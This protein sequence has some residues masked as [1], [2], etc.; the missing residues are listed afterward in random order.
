ML[1]HEPIIKALQAYDAEL[2]AE[3]IILG[4]PP[5]LEMGDVAIP[6]F[7]LAKKR[8]MSPALLAR[9]VV[10]AVD[11]GEHVASAVAVGPYVNLK[12]D[13]NR[14]GYEIVHAVLQ[15]G[16]QWGGGESGLGKRVLIEHTS[17]N[18]NAS[19]HVGRGRCAMIGDSVT[20]LLRFEGYDVEVHYYVNDMGRQIG[21]L[22]L[23][24][25]ELEGIA[26][27]KILEA[28]V[29]ANKRAEDDPDFAAR[30]YA[31]LAKIEEGDN[32]AREKFFRVT[33]LCLQGQLEVLQRLGAR[34]DFFDHES[35][36]VNDARLALI[37]KALEAKDALFTDEDG[38]RVVDLAKLG[39]PAEEGRYFVLR[40]ANG[41]SM[42]GCRD[43]L[44]SLDKYER[45]ADIN[46]MVLGED[47]KLYA[48]QMALILEA[49]G[50]EPPEVIYYSYILL[51]D[52][53]MSTRQGK[54]VLL[55]DFLDQAASQ[56]LQRVMEQ[57][58]DLPDQEH[59]QIAEQVA[60]SAIR[61][62]VL[63]VKPSKNVI[64][65]ME[66]A[67]SF[68]GDTGPYVQYCC[69]R[70]R[71]ILRKW[72]KTVPAPSREGF[73]AEGDSE[74]VLLNAMAAFPK[75]IAD[76][77]VQRNC[78]PIANYVLDLAHAF[79]GF[80]HDC[81]VLSATDERLLHSRLQL[82]RAA[83]YTLSNALGILGIDTPERM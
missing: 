3:D 69:A 52:G 59:R 35:A 64:F 9:E 79:T 80:Y 54:V 51:A 2:D 21:L 72:D 15:A 26:F 18:P 1:Y 6:M 49:A 38:R 13:R 29:T 61:F 7:S 27:D 12:L 82:C 66:S 75:V 53:K 20:R 33:E 30:G 60:V 24:A 25:D 19:P 67:L 74:W 73:R 45:R 76:S 58:P 39:Y 37:E 81:P 23:V 5:A 40:R 56:A 68:Q 57:F 17:I 83:L 10:A 78:A 71:S 41:S 77:A 16:E 8:K 11:F 46:L 55:S 50:I 47:H 31:M 70:I 36:Y 62:A 14:V 4:A 44:Y 28:Y 22:V 34:Y 32:E 63:R 65:D 42:Y 48:Q 43:L